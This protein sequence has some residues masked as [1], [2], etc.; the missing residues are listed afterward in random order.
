[1]GQGRAA[2]NGQLGSVRRLSR[3]SLR[4]QILGRTFIGTPAANVEEDVN[5]CLASRGS[6]LD[7]AQPCDTALRGRD[8]ELAFPGG[9]RI[10]IRC[11]HTRG[12]T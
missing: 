4:S 5:K 6:P 9:V 11:T 12:R 8:V 7:F 2:F 1:M 10:G 3:V